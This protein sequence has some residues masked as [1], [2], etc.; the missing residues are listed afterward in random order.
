M[1]LFSSA[2]LVTSDDDLK[3]YLKPLKKHYK[4]INSG[5]FIMNYNLVLEI[6][7]KEMHSKKKK[8]IILNT[9][10]SD[11][12]IEKGHWVLL[13]IDPY[14]NCLLIDSLASTYRNND[15]FRKVVNLFCYKHGLKLLLWN[16]KTQNSNSQSCGFQIIFFLDFFLRKNILGFKHL[17]FFFK[18]YT[19]F[20]IEKYILSKVYKLCRK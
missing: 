5:E 3:Y 15:N 18:K 6:P 19:L 1:A 12:N 20:Y 7:L 14:K 13:L 4:L 17:E 9:L 16:V 10:S 11:S 2:L 8:G